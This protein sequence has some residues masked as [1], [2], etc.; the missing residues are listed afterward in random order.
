MNTQPT[1]EQRILDAL[2]PNAAV[3]SADVAALIGE[4]EGG[5]ANAEKEATVDATMSLD[6]KAARQAIEEAT[7][8]ADRPVEIAGALPGSAR[9]R[10]INRLAR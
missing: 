4:A 2:Q 7:F 5:I 1:L 10:A 6:P 8:T 9:P 3:T